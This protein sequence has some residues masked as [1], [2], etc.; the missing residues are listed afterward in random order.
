MLT[1]NLHPLA[2]LGALPHAAAAS[3]VP[4]RYYSDWTTW[5]PWTIALVWCV[6][7]AVVYVGV[8]RFAIRMSGDGAIMGIASLVPA[9]IW[10][11]TLSTIAAYIPSEPAVLGI[12][13]GGIVILGV[14]FLLS[15]VGGK[16]G[17]GG[18]AV[19]L[20]VNGVSEMIRRL[21]AEA[22]MSEGTF[23]A[24]S[25]VVGGVIVVLAIGSRAR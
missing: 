7:W 25:V 8:L 19:L 17:A 9:L 12:Y 13:L 23:L 5:Y 2:I 6:A 1:S 21:S 18:A 11:V 16:W 10:T 14:T 15:E 20:V 24:V 22:H 4:A 3:D